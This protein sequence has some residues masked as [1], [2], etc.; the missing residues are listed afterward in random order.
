MTCLC[1]PRLRATL[2]LVLPTASLR[3]AV[4]PAVLT[5]AATLGAAPPAAGGFDLRAALRLGL[6][7]L[8]IPLPQLELIAAS[9]TALGQLSLGLGI[10]LL[11][12]NGPSQLALTLRSLHLNLPRLL[13]LPI[14][15]TAD[16]PATLSLSMALST[17]ASVRAGFG[18]DLLSPGAG[19]ALKLALAPTLA[20]PLPT[21][22]QRPLALRLAA[23][24]KLALAAQA[25]GG[26][27]RLL[28]ALQLLARL[29]LPTIGV[30]L[31]PL[32]ALSLRL[33]LRSQLVALGLD[34]HAP[35][36]ALR[37]NAALRPLWALPPLGLSL[38]AAAGAVTWPSLLPRFAL[39]AQALA[40]L[41][42]RLAA[43]LPLPNLAPF[44]MVASIAAAGGLASA[45]CCG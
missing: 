42:L 11:A 14:G 15:L 25:F 8:P 27:G 28:P 7:P 2:A 32:A 31:G 16:L 6:P 20:L 43:R 5:L 41:N 4:P 13:P 44:S 3:V 35:N 23:Y 38:S 12:P 21:A 40:G 30:G 39:D 19:L 18:I 10:D 36:L 37:L 33:G 17:I 1:L 9:A 24:A 22:S 29:Q 26:V 45:D 34:L